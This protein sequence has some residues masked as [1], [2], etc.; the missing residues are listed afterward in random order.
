MI[1]DSIRNAKFYYSVNENIKTGLQYL[2]TVSPDI[3]LGTYDISP[4]VK[5]LVTE[6]STKTENPQRFESH[7]HVVDIQ[8][9]IIGLEGIEWAHLQGMKKI[10]EYD[11]E[12]D[13]TFYAD[14]IRRTPLVLGEGMFGIFFE[15][16]THNPALA[17]GGKAQVIKKI[18]LKVTL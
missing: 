17:V 6:Y 15:E 2:E 18:T 13:R 1:V 5:V 3:A 14:P 10:T 7:R 12:K 8:F 11:A 9:P 4:K 16:D